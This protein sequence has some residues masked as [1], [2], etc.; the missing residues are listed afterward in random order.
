MSKSKSNASIVIR[1]STSRRIAQKR[2]NDSSMQVVV[3]LEDCYKS[4]GALVVTS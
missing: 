4:A 1:S 2:D 3:A